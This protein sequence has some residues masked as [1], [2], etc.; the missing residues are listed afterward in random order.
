MSFDDEI[1]DDLDRALNE[2]FGV[3][4]LPVGSSQKDAYGTP[5][6]K[7]DDM[8]EELAKASW[9]NS[10]ELGDHIINGAAK[11]AEQ[12]WTREY[13][14]TASNE[15]SHQWVTYDSGFSSFE[16]CQHCN[17]KKA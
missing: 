13:F 12:G 4:T 1:Y 5:G 8:Y 11:G 10:E 6:Y 9:P 15:C 17:T 2:G 14:G 16:Y 7:P 3:T